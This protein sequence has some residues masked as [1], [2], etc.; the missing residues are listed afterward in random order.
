MKYLNS[1]GIENLGKIGYVS[2][3]LRDIRGRV[4]KGD[5]STDTKRAVSMAATWTDKAYTAVCGE[6]D[7]KQGK[8]LIHR[9]KSWREAKFDII[10]PSISATKEVV[11]QELEQADF[12]DMIE[13]SMT[14]GCRDCAQPDKCRFRDLLLKYDVPISRDSGKCPYWNADKTGVRD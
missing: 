9:L 2:G 10:R 12:Y 3:T 8:L 1:D 7:A 11:I 14:G 6:L 13:Y 4:N 5:W